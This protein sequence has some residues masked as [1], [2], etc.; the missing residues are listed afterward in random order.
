MHGR[1]AAALALER[2]RPSQPSAKPRALRRAGVRGGVC[3]AGLTALAGLTGLTSLN[4]D[5]RKFGDAGLTALAP[6]TGL[7]RLDLYS[8]HI[9]SA[10]C[11]AL[12]RAGRQGRVRSTGDALSLPYRRHPLLLPKTRYRCPSGT[13]RCQGAPAGPAP[14]Q[15][16][17]S[18]CRAGAVDV[19]PDQGTRPPPLAA[20]S[21]A[22]M[23]RRAHAAPLA[24]ARALL[25]D[26][27][28]CCRSS[29]H[30]CA[31]R[32]LV[33]GGSTPFPLRS[34]TGGGTWS[35]LSDGPVKR[36]GTGSN[37]CFRPKST[38][39]CEP[40][41]PGVTRP[42]ERGRRPLTAL[43]E[44]EL[45]GGGVGDAGAREL[46]G[47][48]RLRVL[49]LANNGALS[50]RAAPPLARLT[51]LRELNLSGARRITGNGILLFQAL[52]VRVRPRP[53]PRPRA[54]RLR[55]RAAA[56]RGPAGGQ[57]GPL[58]ALDQPGLPGV[59]CSLAAA[60]ATVCAAIAPLSQ[61]TKRAC[62]AMQV[63]AWRWTPHSDHAALI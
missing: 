12:R 8:A 49:S 24:R 17:A 48:S 52:L 33:C 63:S 32:R 23:S 46:G 55:G 30:A 42:R 29:L 6:L 61:R 41:S 13:V 14:E 38:P 19:L 9:T 20:R 36:S 34:S 59:G 22:G 25:G 15:A 18:A 11:S 62:G 47:L 5:S 35:S 57:R 27:S 16:S 58:A 44:L 60:S 2:K 45:C 51:A 7:R 40:P 50:D 10:G 43:E 56:P 21:L 39:T 4:L 26:A 3:D 28:F 54:R 37:I 31:T 53:A 1:S